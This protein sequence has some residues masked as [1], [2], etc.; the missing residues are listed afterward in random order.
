MGLP[1]RRMPGEAHHSLELQVS[2]GDCVITSIK[3]EKSN[4]C[5][6]YIV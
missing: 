1:C 5:T 2:R 4:G 6:Q 3:L